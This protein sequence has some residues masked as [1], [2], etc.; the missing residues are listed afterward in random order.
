MFAPPKNSVTYVAPAEPIDP[1][2]KYLVRL[3]EIK[4]AGESQFADAADPDPAHNLLWTFRLHNMDRTPVLD[5]DLNPYL[6]TDYTSNRTSKGGRQPAKARLWIEALLGREVDDSEIGDALVQ[7]LINKVAV[8]LFEEKE[9]TARDGI[10]KYT[11]LQILRMSPYK[12]GAS[13]A[14]PMPQ[15]AAIPPR[16]PEPA[17][18]RQP[19]ATAPAARTPDPEPELPWN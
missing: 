18:A 11:K 10:T 2:D 3:M 12:D 4:D 8:V 7:Q 17:A 6:H 5:I 9:R 14:A 1:N 15:S 13:Q 16:T 19:V